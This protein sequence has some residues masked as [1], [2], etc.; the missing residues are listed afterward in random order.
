M[1]VEMK[2]VLYIILILP[3]LLGCTKVIED[4][5]IKQH[6]CNNVNG[7][8]VCYPEYVNDNQKR[9]IENILSNM[10]YVKG[11]IFKMG[12]EY[13]IIVDSSNDTHPEY[14]PRLNETPV[15]YVM[16]D[17]FYVSK[18]ELSKEQVEGLLKRDLPEVLNWSYYDWE[19]VVD[20][21]KHYT[22][23]N[24]DIPT[25]AQ[26][27]YVAKGGSKT[28]SYLYPG[29]NRLQ[30]VRSTSQDILSTK[31]PNELGIYNLAD[32][33]S[34]WCKDCY[35]EYKTSS[36]LHNPFNQ[37]GVGHVVRGGNYSSNMFY[38][39]YDN[40]LSEDFSFATWYKEYRISR[41]TSRLFHDGSSQYVGCR[42]VINAKEI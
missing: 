37:Y 42:L 6:S 2:R 31:K 40:V 25:E 4:I 38:G 17:D 36:M 22:N 15:R 26:W 24:F 32:H 9:I 21:L 33:Y 34:E 10:V 16:L 13:D 19:G 27:E 7:F 23:L 39:A 1:N 30:D 8:D 5:D 28:K 41:C 14:Y 18:Y 3:I 11:G 35:I 12:S 20:L 29:A